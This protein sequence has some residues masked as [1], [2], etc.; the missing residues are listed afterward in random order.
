[1]RTSGLGERPVGDE[2]GQWGHEPGQWGDE[3]GQTKCALYVYIQIKYQK[4]IECAVYLRIQ[5]YTYQVCMCV[6]DLIAQFVCLCVQNLQ[7]ST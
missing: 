5:G 2:I 1:M 6:W 7:I 4:Y 3:I